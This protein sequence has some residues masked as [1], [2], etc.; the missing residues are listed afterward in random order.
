[1]V[2]F[3][4]AYIR[5]LQTLFFSLEESSIKAIAASGNMPQEIVD[6]WLQLPQYSFI[7]RQKA[8]GSDI[9]DLLRMELPRAE[10]RK[11]SRTRGDD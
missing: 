1:M 5:H 4:R 10:I 8:G 3:F 7:F 6:K 11:L 2:S 9:Y